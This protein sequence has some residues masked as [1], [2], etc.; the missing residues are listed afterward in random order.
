[1][2][3]IPD[4]LAA[5]DVMAAARVVLGQVSSIRSEL[6]RLSAVLLQQSATIA[7]ALEQLAD[8]S[9]AAAPPGLT[10][11]QPAPALPSSELAAADADDAQPAPPGEFPAPAVPAFAD[12]Q[13]TL[14]CAA[15]ELTES[16]PG[17]PGPGVAMLEDARLVALDMALGGATREEIE[18]EL[19]A[20]FELPDRAALIEDVLRA[21]GRR[22]DGAL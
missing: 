21:I 11:L 12:S 3:P 17:P 13:L 14:A 9:S 15:S 1:M 10:S 22:G 8:A 7:E 6:Q 20:R 18:S 5:D 16:A 4:Q 19:E 2:E